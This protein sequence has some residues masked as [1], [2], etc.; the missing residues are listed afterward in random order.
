M[1]EKTR[2][3]AKPVKKKKE[4]EPTLEHLELL[5][6]EEY[7]LTRPLK[8]KVHHYNDGTVMVE[9]VELN[10]YAEGNSDYDAPNNFSQVLVEQL[11]DLQDFQKQGKRLGRDLRI[12]MN[13]LQRLMKKT[14]TRR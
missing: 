9:S 7:E 10:L 3:K 12:Q 14:G 4:P 5:L 8:I 6:S 13:L 2:S 1:E 11:E